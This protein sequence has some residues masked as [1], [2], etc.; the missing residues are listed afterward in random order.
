[1][2]VGVHE[3]WRSRIVVEEETRQLAWFENDANY[4]R[5]DQGSG[6]GCKVTLKIALQWVCQL[7]ALSNTAPLSTWC[8]T[9]HR[10]Q[11][12]SGNFQNQITRSLSISIS[13]WE[14]PKWTL[15]SM[16]SKL[17][18]SHDFKTRRW[19]HWPTRYWQEISHLN[20]VHLILYQ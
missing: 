16:Y 10:D 12:I 11:S 7:S 6:A 17:E 14:I 20:Y 19:P 4:F 5:T 18:G 1:M 13:R 9:P 3:G 15:Y 2:N 8:P